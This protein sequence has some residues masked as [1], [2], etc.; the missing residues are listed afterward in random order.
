MASHIALLRAV[1]VGGRGLKMGDLAAFARDLDLGEPRTLLQSGNLVFESPA[2]G[3]AALERRLEAEAEKRF[4]FPIDFMVRSAAEWRALMRANPFTAAARDDPAHLLV[5]PLKA[6]P[7]KGALERLRAAIKGPEVV[8]VTVRD[9]YLVYPDGIGR[10]KLTLTVIE[11]A[12][13]VRGTAR[14]WNTVVK[15]AEMLA[16]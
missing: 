15:L 7:A 3:T 5:M 2:R 1:N 14:N 9:A 13:G 4:G 12:L 8:D 11:K 16:G 6:A 10:S